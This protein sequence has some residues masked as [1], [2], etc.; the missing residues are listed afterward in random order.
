MVLRQVAM[1]HSIAGCDSWTNLQS[2]DDYPMINDDF[3]CFDFLSS[4]WLDMIRIMEYNWYDMIANQLDEYFCWICWICW[5]WW[6]STLMRVLPPILV[7]FVSFLFARHVQ[8]I[9][10]L[11]AWLGCANV[12]GWRN[13]ENFYTI[14][15]SFVGG[16]K[17]R[18]FHCQVWLPES[19]GCRAIKFSNVTKHHGDWGYIVL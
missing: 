15:G 10:A 5:I 11:W 19:N 13:L 17:W 18:V 14:N 3:P 2:A 6:F 1:P 8:V 7:T 9:Q 12:A 16:K 4:M